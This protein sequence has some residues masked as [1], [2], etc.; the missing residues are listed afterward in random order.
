MKQPKPSVEELD[1]W[2]TLRSFLSAGWEQKAREHGALKRA[3]GIPDAA[4]LLR[5]L[6]IHVANGCSL[7]ETSVRARQMGWAN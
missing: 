6:L 4:A 1:D 2:E 5:V 3:R 7:A